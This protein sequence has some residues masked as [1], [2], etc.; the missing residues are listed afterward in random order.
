MSTASI[1]NSLLVRCSVRACVSGKALE[2]TSAIFAWLGTHLA[3]HSLKSDYTMY[4]QKS[5]LLGLNCWAHIVHILS[6]KVITRCV[7][8]SQF[9]WFTWWA[10]IVEILSYKVIPRC[11]PGKALQ[12]MLSVLTSAVDVSMWQLSVW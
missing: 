9:H 2:K 4:A 8:K 1:K 3:H 12:K 11:V 5:S 6:N 10:H 7:P